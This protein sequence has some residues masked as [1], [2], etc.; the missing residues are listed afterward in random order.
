[1][2][3]AKSFR[4]LRTYE[5]AREGAKLVF[6]MTKSFP[7]EERYSMTDQV[8]RSSRAVKAM[9]A[10]AWAKRRYKASFVN[11]IGDAMG[12]AM[13]TQS[14]L[15]DALD[16]G[17]ISPEVFAQLD[18]LWQSVGGMLANMINRADDFCKNPSDHSFLREEQETYGL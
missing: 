5:K 8:R 11:K 3:I 18:E 17:Y 10:E 12:E 6:E 14:W 15:D 9:L 4:E 2:A 1:M 16:C 13:E 7:K